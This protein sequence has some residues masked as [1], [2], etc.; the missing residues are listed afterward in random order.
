MGL[1]I[2][3][4]L[5]LQTLKQFLLYVIKSNSLPLNLFIILKTKYQSSILLN[6][7]VGLFIYFSKAII[8]LILSRVYLGRAFHFRGYI[9]IT[10]RTFSDFRPSY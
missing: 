4:S 3:F 10:Y 9:R 1:N 2:S 7:M 6:N 5:I 8:I